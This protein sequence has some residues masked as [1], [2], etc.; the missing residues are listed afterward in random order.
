MILAAGRGERMRPLSDTLPKPLLEV[1]A[2]ALIIYHIEKL[3]KNGFKEIV[4]NIAHLGYKIPESLGNGSR[5]GV[6]IHYSDEQNE[7]ALESAGGIIK[8]LPL[9]SKED[10]LVVNGDIWCDYEFDSSFDLGDDLAHLILVKNP[11][12]NPDGDFALK[13]SRVLNDADVKYTF[14]G[15]GYYKAEFFQ[16][17]PCAK[18]ALAPLLREAIKEDKISGELFDGVFRDIGTPQRL[19]EINKQI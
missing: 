5:W 17:L 7:G 1:K 13:K 2:K 10:F 4:I 14:A 19:E 16:N 18:L 6:K 3:A 8:A 11:D 9:L 15:I 12:H